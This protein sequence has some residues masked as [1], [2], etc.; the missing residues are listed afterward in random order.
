MDADSPN[1]SL[2]PT[3]TC[4]PLHPEIPQILN[5]KIAYFSSDQQRWRLEGAIGEVGFII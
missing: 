1:K 4:F 2:L 5:F 3:M